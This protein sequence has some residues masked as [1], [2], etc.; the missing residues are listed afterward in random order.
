M[1]VC[2]YMCED[3]VFAF[4]NH[5]MTD[6]GNTYSKADGYGNN[7]RYGKDKV[8]HFFKNPSDFKHI[9]NIKRDNRATT[10]YLGAFDI[11]KRHLIFRAGRGK[12][13]DVSGYDTLYESI[14]E[15]ALPTKVV[16]VDYFQYFVKDNKRKLTA[17]EIV[18]LEQK[19]VA[20]HGD[21]L[22]GYALDMTGALNDLRQP[23]QVQDSMQSI[24]MQEVQTLQET[25]LQSKKVFAENIPQP[26]V[27]KSSGEE[28]VSFKTEE[29]CQ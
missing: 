22:L 28:K 9:K 21:N 6:V 4:I 8:L 13:D 11:P 15:Y 27:Q 12:Y 5:D 3:E 1:R 18:A 26:A 14:R 25:P 29:R 24:Q 2:R 16:K 7:H 23:K 19:F 17:N 10:F 20:E